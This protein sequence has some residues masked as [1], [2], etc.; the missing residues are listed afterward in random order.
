MVLLDNAEL[1]TYETPDPDVAEMKDK[2]EP[3]VPLKVGLQPI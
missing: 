2:P 1:G 3:A